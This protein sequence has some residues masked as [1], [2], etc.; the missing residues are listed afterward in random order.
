MKVQTHR[1]TRLVTISLAAG[2]LAAPAAS[3][4]PAPADTPSTGEPVFIE[5]H[6]A[7]V[8]QSVDEGFDW[9]SA[10]IGAGGAGALI[11]LVSAGGITYRHR[12][13]HVGI[14]R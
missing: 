4:R 1:I 10:A 12:H 6:P 8:V 13:E 7:P 2:A 14:A 9:G 11:L 3:A 5:P